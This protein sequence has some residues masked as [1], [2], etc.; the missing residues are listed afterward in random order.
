VRGWKQDVC[1]M[2]SVAGLRGSVLLSVFC[3]CRRKLERAFDVGPHY[4]MAVSAGHLS[5][6]ELFNASMSKP[7]DITSVAEALQVANAKF[8]SKEKHE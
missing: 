4:I 2:V 1:S 3:L 5:N 7:L 8:R 6:L